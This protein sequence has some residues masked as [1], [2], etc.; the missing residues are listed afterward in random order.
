MKSAGKILLAIL[1]TTGAIFA[2]IGVGYVAITIYLNFFFAGNDC[3]E[4]T[5][6][7]VMSPNKEYSA[8]Q[9][10]SSCEKAGT[11]EHWLGVEK[12][13]TGAFESKRQGVL[14]L[15][16]DADKAGSGQMPRLVFEWRSKDELLVKYPK[17][18]G[19]KLSNYILSDVN[20]IT[21]SQ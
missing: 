20:V 12:T 14:F 9:T 4:S 8:I 16:E 11:V 21:E 19:I 17:N 1:V 2:L 13:K 18:R 3:T 7:A 10:T 5:V 15:K 6:V